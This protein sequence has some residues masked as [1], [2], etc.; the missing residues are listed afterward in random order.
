MAQGAMDWPLSRSEKR[1]QILRLYDEDVRAADNMLL[2]GEEAL[3]AVRKELEEVRRAAGIRRDSREFRSKLKADEEAQEAG[4]C[5]EE[6]T[7]PESEREIQRLRAAV[8]SAAAVLR[9]IVPAGEEEDL[10]ADGDAASSSSKVRARS[11]GANRDSP[12]KGGL[13]SALSRT[14]RTSRGGATPRKRVSFGQPEEEPSQTKLQFSDD[15]DA[16]ADKDD[17]IELEQPPMRRKKIRDSLGGDAEVA[18][19]QAAADGQSR[20]ASKMPMTWLLGSLAL[21][22]SIGAAA[23]CAGA[24][25]GGGAPSNVKG[26]PSCWDGAFSWDMCCHPGFGPSGNPTCW[27]QSYTHKRCC[28]PPEEL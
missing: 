19:N 10:A 18:F 27:D 14:P 26:N 11:E 6:P 16:A 21:A 17:H 7:T 25:Q 2:S 8:E 1:F 22:G 20:A 28:A 13:R 3:K 4:G 9:A 5:E 15:E 24:R 12:E 23:Y